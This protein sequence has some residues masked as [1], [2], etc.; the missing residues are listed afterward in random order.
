MKRGDKRVGL[1][2]IGPR[3]GNVGSYSG[4]VG[5]KAGVVDGMLKYL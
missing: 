4:E 2:W 5:V 3:G 1:G